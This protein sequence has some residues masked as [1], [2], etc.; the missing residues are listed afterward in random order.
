MCPVGNLPSAYIRNKGMKSKSCCL[1]YEMLKVRLT[2]IE[3]QG[4]KGDRQFVLANK[5][6]RQSKFCTGIN[7]T[8]P[9]LRPFMFLGRFTWKIAVKTVS[10]CACGCVYRREGDRMSTLPAYF[11]APVQL[12]RAFPENSSSSLP[13]LLRQ[14]WSR[15]LEAHRQNEAQV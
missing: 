4:S 6:S 5:I 10:V 3:N 8:C 13:A 11:R 9:Y 14:L 15:I 2:E 7:R 12:Q 1:S